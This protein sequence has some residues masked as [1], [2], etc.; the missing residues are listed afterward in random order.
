M[1][2]AQERVDRERDEAEARRRAEEGEG[3][4]EEGEEGKQE[5]GKK[6]G[7]AAQSNYWGDEAVQ[8]E[9]TSEIEQGYARED[10]L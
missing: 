6:G 4:G 1:R 10:A 2:E 9:W 3:E 8:D 5:R 7:E